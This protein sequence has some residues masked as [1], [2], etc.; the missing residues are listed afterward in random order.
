MRRF[1]PAALLGLLLFA[2]ACDSDPMEPDP[3]MSF[4]LTGI[5]LGEVQSDTLI[6]RI[7]MNLTEDATVITGTGSARSL[8]DTLNYDIRGDYVHP[9]VSLALVYD[10]PPPGTLAGNV[11]QERDVINGTISGPGFSGVI[12]MTLRRQN[13]VTA[14]W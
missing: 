7:E 4:S 11:N 14:A 2:T 3:P 6:Y 5:W 10:R 12:E 13:A 1:L 9:L 8:R